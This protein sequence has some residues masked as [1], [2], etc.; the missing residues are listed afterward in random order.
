MDQSKLMIIRAVRDMARADGRLHRNEQK[1]LR[2]IA[3]AEDLSDE[4]KQELRGSMEPVDISELKKHLSRREDQLR[5]YQLSA[6]VSLADGQESP[7]ELE[8]LRDLGAAFELTK[9]EIM[10]ALEEARDRF[11]SLTREW[12]K[13]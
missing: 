4:E 7:E 3:Q 11:F 5:L 9:Q 10:S 8:R 12:D 2:L 13:E 6:L 1:L